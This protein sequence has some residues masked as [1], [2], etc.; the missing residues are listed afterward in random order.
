MSATVVLSP[1]V[2]QMDHAQKRSAGTVFQDAPFGPKPTVPSREIVI[3]TRPTTDP[4]RRTEV[5]GGV[6]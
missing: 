1:P 4:L 3:V 5:R 6:G 2:G